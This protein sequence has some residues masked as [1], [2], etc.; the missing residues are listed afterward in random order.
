MDLRTE[1]IVS[2]IFEYKKNFSVIYKSTQF[3]VLDITSMFK[4]ALKLFSLD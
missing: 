3:D 1:I 4:L 2:Q